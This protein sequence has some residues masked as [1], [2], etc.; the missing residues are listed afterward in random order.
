MNGAVFSLCGKYRYALHRQWMGGKNVACFIMLNPSTADA[1]QDDPTIRRCVNYAKT[2][3]FE[4]LSVLNIFAYRSTDPD[5]LHRLSE[6]QAIGPENDDYIV[7]VAAIATLVVC[8]R[9]THGYLFDRG[10]KV[11]N[12]LQSKGVMPH[13]LRFTKDGHP[14][15]PLYLPKTLEPKPWH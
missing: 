3:G 5:A 13:V 15:H 7:A 6:S 2:W 14:A 1:T 8:A 9:G 4:T 11:R 10:V 12:A